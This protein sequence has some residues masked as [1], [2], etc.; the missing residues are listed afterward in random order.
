M[1]RVLIVDDERLARRRIRQLLAREEDLQVVG[2]AAN[3]VDAVRLIEQQCPDLL[4]LDVQM[5]ELNGFGVIEAI[6]ADRMPPTLF[7]TAYDQYAVKAFEVRALDYLLKPFDRQRFQKAIVRAREWLLRPP[8]Q[9]SALNGLL[10]Q[11]RADAPYADRFVVRTGDR[12]L[13]VKT[14]AVQWIGAED[15]YVRLHVEGASYLLR[16]TMT[17]TLSRLDPGL[18]RRIHRSVI[19]N[20]EFVRELR[21]CGDGDMRVTMCDGTRLTLRR[22]YRAQFVT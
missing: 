7:V 2:E 1:I 16:Q 10:D 14:R 20:L 19:V 13:M 3:G 21:P 4:F 11:V 5:P 9:A 6:G 15:N 18:F 12:Y 17:A 22:A 8:G